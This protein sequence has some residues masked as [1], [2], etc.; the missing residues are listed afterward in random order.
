M[1][2]SDDVGAV[3][4]IDLNNITRDE[5]VRLQSEEHKRFVDRVNTHILCCNLIHPGSD[6]VPRTDRLLP[7]H[8]PLRIAIRQAI[9]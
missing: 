7:W 1:E 9:V 2:R 3:P 8:N 4:T 5:A 6:T